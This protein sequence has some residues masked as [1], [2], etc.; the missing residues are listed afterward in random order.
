MSDVL[1]RQLLAVGQHFIGKQK[2]RRVADW[3]YRTRFNIRRGCPAQVGNLMLIKDLGLVLTGWVIDE[4]DPLESIRIIAGQQL[5]AG[6]AA[7]WRVFRITDK[8][9]LRKFGLA[10]SSLKPALVALLPL[11]SGIISALADEADA[12][13]QVVFELQS[14]ERVVRSRQPTISWRNPL[15]SIRQ[16][17]LSS[18][19][20]A[21]NKRELFDQIYGPALGHI[22]ASRARSTDRPV[23]KHYNEHLAPRE[24]EVSVVIPIY[25]RYDFIEYQLSQFVDDPDMRRHELLYVID[26]PSIR[27]QVEQLANSIQ[28]VY[29]MAFSI[30]YLPENLGFSGANNVGVQF[31]RSNRL[32]LMN[33]DIIPFESGWLG[34]L[35]ATVSSAL[36]STITGVRLLYE[37]MS[38]QHDGMSFE[39]SQAH[40]G[41]WIN[42]HPSKGIPAN[43]VS[44]QQSCRPAEAVTGACLLLSRENFVS[45]GGFDEAYILG[46]FEDSDLCLRA[47]ERGLEI[48][49]LDSIVLCHL[50][51]QS[52]SLVSEDRWKQELTY[53]NCWY[54]SSKW[55][56]TITQ[57][58]AEVVCE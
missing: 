34:R 4:S 23:T 48:Q 49:M 14:G 2:T 7:D 9:L 51:R 40:N 8:I 6:E 1:Q 32:L 37:D 55:D 29:R 24:P 38:V 30:I 17:L 46:D 35:V 3:C 41:L 11:E 44:K 20:R 57:L 28:H 36:E 16:L 42:R 19:E 45:L 10:D 26:D 56:S 58:K 33:S 27:S 22:W 52:Q 53:Y 5:A 43:L 39:K 21:A 31:A 47:R 54:H 12:A 18:P 15:E 50:E 25:G 13:W